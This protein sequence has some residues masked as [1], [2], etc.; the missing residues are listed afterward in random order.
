MT[1]YRPIL[2][3]TLSNTQYL[4]QLLILA[5]EP[6][7]SAE[8]NKNDQTINSEGTKI[9]QRTQGLET[10]SGLQLSSTSNDSFTNYR[11]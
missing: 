6:F 11:T 2:N 3:L 4:S 9:L 5:R 10:G 7:L 8:Y 1:L